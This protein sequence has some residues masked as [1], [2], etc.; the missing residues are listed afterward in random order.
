ME[1][2]RKRVEKA[3]WNFVCGFFS[4]NEL[5]KKE[6]KER[7]EKGKILIS[8]KKPVSLPLPRF[9]ARTHVPLLSDFIHSSYD[10]PS[11][12]SIIRFSI[13]PH[14][15]HCST[16]HAKRA[17]ISVLSP[18]SF[19]ISSSCSRKTGKAIE[20][21]RKGTR[22]A[23]IDPLSSRSSKSR[24][25]R[26]RSSRTKA[27]GRVWPLLPWW[28]TDEWWEIPDRSGWCVGGEWTRPAGPR[29][30]TNP[31]IGF[32]CMGLPW[33]ERDG[34]IPGKGIPLVCISWEE[35]EEEE[36]A[37]GWPP[38]GTG[39]LPAACMEPLRCC[40]II[41]I[42]WPRRREDER[43]GRWLLRG[44]LAGPRGKGLKR[45]E[46]DRRHLH[47]RI[48]FASSSL[49][50]RGIS[51]GGIERS[52]ALLIAYKIWWRKICPGDGWIWKIG[53][54]CFDYPLTGIILIMRSGSSSRSAA[55]EQL[56]CTTIIAHP[57]ARIINVVVGAVHD[58]GPRCD[59]NFTHSA[60]GDLSRSVHPRGRGRAGPRNLQ[61]F[62]RGIKKKLP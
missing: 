55:A 39:L 46:G 21:S 24:S 16:F 33:M 35:E 53:G 59:A 51:I 28:T 13:P 5:K 20:T 58:D 2:K 49:L 3:R 61:P 48:R 47:D 19:R 9:F 1:E 26:R 23:T 25:L 18:R 44:G 37:F 52:I 22:P 40:D 43:A 17:A 6:K 62:T 54:R 50:S 56:P 30:L 36:A 38:P 34:T 10:V 27:K 12:L 11:P 60:C 57:S 29:G 7:G 14:D 15:H 32:P 45:S 41:G 4:R 8:Y 31:W 42:R